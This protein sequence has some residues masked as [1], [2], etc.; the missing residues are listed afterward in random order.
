[1]SVDGWRDGSDG[2]AAREV[3]EDLCGSGLEDLGSSLVDEM[4]E[5]DARWERCGIWGWRG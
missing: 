4:R 1:M 5:R 3:V 2:D